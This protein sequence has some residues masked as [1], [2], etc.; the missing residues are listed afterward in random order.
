M[1]SNREKEK[2]EKSKVK[3]NK[4]NTV[5]KKMKNIERKREKSVHVGLC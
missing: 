5:T 3:Q 1:T 2:A 4:T